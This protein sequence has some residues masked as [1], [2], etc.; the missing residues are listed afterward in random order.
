[1]NFGKS[2]SG[3]L[4]T[5]FVVG[6]SALPAWA[7]KKGKP[8]T[9]GTNTSIPFVL[10]PAAPAVT[11]PPLNMVNYGGSCGLKSAIIQ[12]YTI[13]RGKGTTPQPPHGAIQTWTPDYLSGKGNGQYYFFHTGAL[14][15]GEY[16][17]RTQMVMIGYKTSWFEKTN[18]STYDSGNS[19]RS[20]A[21]L[22]GSITAKSSN[23]I[24]SGFPGNSW[25]A[26]QLNYPTVASGIS[27]NDVAN[28]NYMVSLQS[29]N[30]SGIYVQVNTQFNASLPGNS[31]LGEVTYQVAVKRK[32]NGSWSTL[33]TATTKNKDY[34]YIYES[35]TGVYTVKL[36][37]T[38]VVSSVDISSVTASK[39]V[40]YKATAYNGFQIGPKDVL[41]SVSCP[42]ENF[43]ELSKE[44]NGNFGIAIDGLLRFRHDEQY[45]F[46]GPLDFTVYDQYHTKQ[47]NITAADLTSST[48]DYGDNWLELDIDELAPGMYMLE[49]RNSKGESKYLRFKVL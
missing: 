11:M 33:G 23:E 29:S 38:T 46:S 41:T 12:D 15:T 24:E 48:V 6:G 16:G 21:T 28:A 32:L 35:N 2:V 39:R 10:P 22:N 20:N 49:A 37:N 44:V 31:H 27:A 36:N 45:N 42:P 18:A 7:V 26:F 8:V 5:L 4:M 25:Y 19:I 13:A 40:H 1:M 30:G 34:V 14:P 47:T 17:D 9:R 3:L 43:Y